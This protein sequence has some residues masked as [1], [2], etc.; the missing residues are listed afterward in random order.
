MYS[1]Q[2]GTTLRYSGNQSCLSEDHVTKH[3]DKY[4]YGCEFEFYVDTSK[5]DFNQVI[6]VLIHDLYKLSSADILVNTVELPDSIDKNQCIQIKP[7]ISLGDTGVEISIPISSKEGVQHFIETVFPLIEC[8]GHTNIETGFHIHISTLKEDG[9][10]FNFYKFML[11]CEDQKLLNSWAPR[12]GYSQNVMD[13][14]AYTNKLESRKIKTK[15]GT[16]WNLERISNNHVEIKTIGG[17]NY[18]QNTDQVIQEFHQYAKCFE[19]TLQEN[20]LEHK[21]IIKAHQE[22]VSTLPSE[23]RVAFMNALKTAGIM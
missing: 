17:E 13:I 10:N 22:H 6:E 18:H 3:D 15:K 11:L 23:V 16:I 19:E 14:L 21:R 20:S 8:Y 1:T 2:E 7:D 5:Q 4:Q 9:V 12:E